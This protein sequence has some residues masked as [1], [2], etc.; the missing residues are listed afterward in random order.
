MIS[1][2]KKPVSILLVFMMIV[3]LFAAVPMTVNAAPPGATYTATFTFSP[4]LV[5]R[6]VETP[7]RGASNTMVFPDC[8]VY[9]TG[10][11]RTQTIHNTSV[12][13]SH[14]TAGSYDLL[15]FNGQEIYRGDW[16][17]PDGIRI[18]SGSGTSSDP[19]VTEWYSTP[20]ITWKLDEDTVIDT[21]KV[22]FDAVP[23]HAA[24][25]KEPDEDYTYT[26]AGWSPEPVAV[27]DDAT[28]TATFTAVPR[29]YNVN[30]ETAEHGTVTANPAEA[31]KGNQVTLTAEPD[32]GYALSSI[33]AFKKNTN[34][35]QATLTALD[36]SSTGGEG[37]DKLVDGNTN[38]KWG[39]NGGSGYI[40][41]K[42]DKAF[43]LNDYSLTTA[44][45]TN[46]YSGR[47]WK[48]WEIYGAN[49]AS[50][51]E[52]VKNSDQWQLVT[53]VTNDSKL[54]ATNF[55]RY[56]YSVNTDPEAY[57]YYK[58]EI[59]ANKGDGYTQMSELTLSSANYDVEVV[60]M[61]DSADPAK[62][63]FEMPASNVTVKAE[64]EAI[65]TYTVTWKNGDETLKTETVAKGTTPTYDGE[66]P[67]KADGADCIYTFSGWTPEVTAV[68]GDVTYTAQFTATEKAPAT[69]KTIA[70]GE[71]Y[72]IGDSIAFSDGPPFVYVRYDDDPIYGPSGATAYLIGGE[73]TTVTAPTYSTRDGQWKFMD[74]LRYNPWASAR[75]LNITAANDR[76][77]IGFKCS[78]G[79]GT[80][81]DPFTF[82]CVFEAEEEN[83]INY[84]GEHTLNPSDKVTVSGEDAGKENFGLNL[85]SY[86]NMQMLGIQL[87][88]SIPT[89]GGDDGVRFVTAVNSKLLKGSNIEDYGYIVAKFNA[90][91]EDLNTNMDKFTADKF[92]K[93]I[94]VF[95]CKGTSNSISGD[96]GQYST[97]T[98]YK[99][100]T[101]AVTG[102]SGKSG[103]LIARFY[104]KTKDGKYHYADYINSSNQ[105]YSGMAFDLSAVSANLH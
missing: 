35:Q 24:P 49:F 50:D 26:F 70:A 5:G 65:P 100:V 79:T 87:K 91:V 92:E 20:T 37:Y 46:N 39:F 101:L 78:G 11:T 28:Y 75:P 68:T 97:E 17:V 55:T 30:V 104:V 41:V 86:L 67:Y 52:A 4:S 96:F 29:P 48:N 8:D 40:I 36:G 7:G 73:N 9:I 90:N 15:Y 16:A 13:Y 76:T 63:T 81:S 23:T 10:V 61:Q 85:G 64:F 89:E 57:Q 34:S 83:G 47:N 53:S 71:T 69:V 84:D 105:T 27:T 1:K 54:Q 18:V 45:D 44:N 82:E 80:S 12:T 66:T 51:S 6:Y 33:K 14:S 94:N 98:D 32:A 72:Y 103:N 56:D 43:I 59:S 62:Y 22:P 88:N 93:D 74:V 42:A 58:I 99:Y 77:P 25:T 21:T 3:S 2:I 60:L 19:Y 102:T 38:T 31:A 95:T